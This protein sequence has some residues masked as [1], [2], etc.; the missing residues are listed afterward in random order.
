MTPFLQGL[1]AIGIA[2][3]AFCLA[4]A[5]LEWRLR[6][7]LG[8]AR[9]VVKALKT[10]VDSFEHSWDELGDRIN[11]VSQRMDVLRHEFQPVKEEVERHEK[12]LR[13]LRVQE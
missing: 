8:E 1:Q 7:H 2:V 13:R 10:H 9:G 11:K 3:V 5:L 4:L 12:Q 6:V